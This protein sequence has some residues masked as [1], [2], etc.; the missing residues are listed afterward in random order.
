MPLALKIA[1]GQFDPVLTEDLTQTND[2]TPLSPSTSRE[3]RKTEND[4][5]LTKQFRSG[6]SLEPHH[7][8]AFAPG[9]RPFHTIIPAALLDGDDRW[10]AVLGVT[11]GQF[12]PQGHV[13]VLVNMLDHGLD[14]Q[15]ALDA[16]RYRLEEDGTV[17][18]EPPLAGIAGEFDRP[19][20]VVDDLHNFGNGHLIRR[21]ADGVLRGGT[22]PRRDGLALGV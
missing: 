8:N 16:P 9:K 18:L 1:A 4:L 22:E 11:G 10:T 14:P 17:S 13:Q 6:F 20:T 15:A 7:P 5:G 21:E 3:E 19:A 2:H 12:Q